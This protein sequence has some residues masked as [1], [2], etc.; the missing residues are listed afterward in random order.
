MKTTAALSLVLSFTI[1]AQTIHPELWPSV[2]PAVPRD[3]RL[4]KRVD[5][6]LR[7]MTLEEKA[8]QVI[9]AS[10]TT[11]KPEDIRTYHLGS[12]LNGVLWAAGTNALAELLDPL[13]PP[14]P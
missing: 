4:E 12:V 1:H 7:R 10:I 14:P 13:P 9:Q 6:I 11:V 8:G 2:P 3:A 5:D